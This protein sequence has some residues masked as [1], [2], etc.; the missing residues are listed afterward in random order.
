MRWQAIEPQPSTAILDYWFPRRDTSKDALVAATVRHHGNAKLVSLAGG[1]GE[2]F[3]QNHAPALRQFLGK[4]AGHAFTTMVTLD[5]PASV[6]LVLRKRADLLQAHLINTTGM[7][8]A[9]RY[10]AIDNVVP[11]PHVTLRLCTTRAPQSVVPQPGDQRL[12]F[13]WNA[14]VTELQCG[15]LAMYDIVEFEGV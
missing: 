10:A 11:V 12:E 5:A 13:R 6:E 8:L 1:L 2:V 7:Q 15:P 3:G 9:A 4:L 14:G